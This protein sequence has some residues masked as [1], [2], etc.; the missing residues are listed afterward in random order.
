MHEP[1]DSQ[2]SD[3]IAGRIVPDHAAVALSETQIAAI[4]TARQSQRP[5]RRGA[6]VASVS[7][8]FLLLCAS[9]SLL[10]ALFGVEHLIA[11]VLLAGLGVVE[12]RGASGLRAARPG[13][14]RMLMWNQLCLGL[15]VIAYGSLG[16]VRTLVSDPATMGFSEQ[17]ATFLEQN[18]DMGLS[19]LGRIMWVAMLGLYG[20][21]IVFGVACQGAMALYYAAKERRLRTWRAATPPWAVEFL[22]QAA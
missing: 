19:G 17:T 20:G 13:A 2:L 4:R 9:G 3:H 7:G 5:L 18:P 6:A 15:L 11:A 16:L 10:L 8:T 12:L 14:G 21:V 1:R 22:Q